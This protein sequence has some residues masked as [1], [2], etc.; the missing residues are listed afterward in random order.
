[1]T[2]GESDRQLSYAQARGG[3]KTHTNQPLLVPLREVHERLR[4]ADGCAQEALTIGVLAN[5]LE[6]G[7]HGGGP[8]LL[9]RLIFGGGGFQAQDGGLGWEGGQ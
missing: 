9:A 6:N 8:L 3:S 5:A 1:M 7:A 4:V 2:S